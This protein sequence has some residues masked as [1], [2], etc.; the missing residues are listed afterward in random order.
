M[1]TVPPNS[2]QTEEEK[3]KTS[4]TLYQIILLVKGK[5]VI[6]KA[7]VKKEEIKKTLHI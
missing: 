7:A 2:M 1:T 5:I 4:R 3:P 6:Y